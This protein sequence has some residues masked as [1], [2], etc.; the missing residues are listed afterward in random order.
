M[1]SDV[2]SQITMKFK[3]KMTGE[4]ALVKL[5]LYKNNKVSEWNV[6]LDSIPLT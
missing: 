3:D 6:K 4:S 1:Q 2:V 5:R